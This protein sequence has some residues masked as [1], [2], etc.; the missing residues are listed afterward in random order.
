MQWFSDGS[1]TA[2]L[3]MIKAQ[4]NRREQK[5]C[6]YSYTHILNFDSNKYSLKPK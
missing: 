4:K 1:A 5:G 6:E 2:N 3:A